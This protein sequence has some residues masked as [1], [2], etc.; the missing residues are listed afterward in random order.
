MDVCPTIRS[1]IIFIE[2]TPYETIP[3]TNGYAFIYIGDYQQ[4][5]CF[6]REIIDTPD[7]RKEL[8]VISIDT[9]RELGKH[10]FISK[11]FFPWFERLRF[12]GLRHFIKN[13]FNDEIIS[14]E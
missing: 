5:R 13:F 1:P 9:E 10:L 7:F 2:P 4:L 8:L 6:A 12:F 3:C 11:R 14:L